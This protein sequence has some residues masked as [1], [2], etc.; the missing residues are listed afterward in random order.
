MESIIKPELGWWGKKSTMSKVLWIGIPVAIIGYFTRE[1]WMPESWRNGSADEAKPDTTKTNDTTAKT[2]VV[3]NKVNDDVVKETSET[4]K[5]VSDS[6]L[7]NG[8][9][10]S[11]P[12]I[13]TFGRDFN[14]VKSSGIWHVKSKVNPATESTKNA[15]PEWTILDGKTVLSQRLNVR[16]PNL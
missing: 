8:G 14:F 9:E 11:S 4:K 5:I 7:P 1:H 6:T 15:F 3:D 10:N 13:E 16:Y 2:E 12:V